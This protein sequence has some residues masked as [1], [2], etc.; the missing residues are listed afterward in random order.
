MW[1]LLKTII[2]SKSTRKKLNGKKAEPKTKMQP[3]Q[4]VVTLSVIRPN[5]AGIDIGDTMHVVA[6][7]PGRSNEQVKKFGAF[8]CDLQEI[9]KWLKQCR[10][11]TVAMESTGVYWIPLFALLIQH[12]FEVY[13]V[14]SRH[15]KN[16]S[17]K[18]TDMEDAV[19]IQ[20][21]HSCGLL[22]RSFLPD[23]LT[24]TLRTLVRQR[25]AL[26]QDSNRCI[27]RI[28]KNLEMMNIKIHTVI[29]DITGKTGKAIIEAII[30]GEREAKKF[31]P[32]ID[33]RIQASEEEIVKSLE[34]NWRK[35]CLFLIKQCYTQYQQL[36]EHIRECEKEIETLL[37]QMVAVQNEGIIEPQEDKP[38]QQ[39][40]E[41][42]ATCKEKK[43]K[44]KKNKNTPC[45]DVRQY[46]QRIHGVD[47]LEIF[48]ISEISG[49]EIL[50]ET[51]TDLS[52]WETGNRFV[53]WLNLCPNNKITGGKLISSKLMS[54]KPNKASQAFRAAANGLKNSDN[55][56]GDYFRRMKTKGGHKY[57]IVATAR[58]LALIYYKIVKNKIAFTPMDI[59]EYREKHKKSKIVY[60]EKKLAELRKEAA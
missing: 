29:R 15:T 13:L 27:Q 42:M 18:K 8:T 22:T 23:D 32:L 24:E 48:G 49:L 51:G 28:Q 36:Q 46:L 21:L 20:R 53:K 40:S 35:E 6:V 37:Q 1:L 41:T 34:G 19:W 50:A 52:K 26:I 30:K 43:N 9:V 25:K 17:G 5:A 57:A 12:G 2:M 16:V 47:V 45:Y 10:V 11:D 33:V 58:K 7:P 39:N 14:N 54:K 4:E 59:N 44:K 60:Y 31:L 3:E 38:Q 55:W 56:L